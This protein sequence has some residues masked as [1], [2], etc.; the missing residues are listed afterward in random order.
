[1]QSGAVE[2]WTARPM[3]LEGSDC[4]GLAAVLDAGERDRLARLRFE[5]DQR[6]FIVSHAMRRIA[7][8]LLLAADPQD[9]RFGSGPHGQPILLDSGSAPVAFSLSRS[10]DLVACA[11][12]AGGPV[13]VD[14]EP[15]RDGVDAALLDPYMVLP[16]QAGAMAL[17][18]FYAR[19]TALEA[20][21]KA[22]GLGLSQAH[23]RIALQAVGEGCFDVSCGGEPTGLQAIRLPSPSS[24]VLSVVCEP[25]A[26]LRMVELGGLA[27]RAPSR[28]HGHAGSGDGWRPAAA[29]P[30]ILST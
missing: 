9:L 21:W 14:L 15:V 12:S 17:D 4:A 18:S 1:M 2:V 11:V 16:P 19:W 8:G 23:P 24:H 3:D 5:S 13:G 28:G 26:S 30:G 20:F 25:V 22:R 6:A 7:V 10:R 29:A 27:Q